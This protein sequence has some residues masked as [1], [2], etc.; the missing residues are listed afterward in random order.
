MRIDELNLIR[1]GRFKDRTL[2]FPAPGASGAPDLHLVIGDNEAGKSTLRK[3]IPEWIWG[4]HPQS[5]MWIGFQQSE[6]RIGGQISAHGQS[7]PFIRKKGRTSTLLDP[8][9]A[10]LPESALS[11]YLAGISDRAY[12]E[13]MFCLD[14]EAMRAGGQALLSGDSKDRFA[15]LLFESAAGIATLKPL[16]EQLEAEADELF[17]ARAKASRRY[18]IALQQMNDA[19]SAFRECEIRVRTYVQRKDAVTD[20]QGTLDSLKR[21]R[22]DLRRQKA[23]LTRVKLLS[24]RFDQLFAHQQQRDALGPLPALP[25]DAQA[26]VQKTLANLARHRAELQRLVNE[27][28]EADRQIAEMT[29]DGRLEAAGPEIS[30]LSEQ[31]AQVRAARADLPQVSRDL[32]TNTERVFVDA[33]H[34]GWTDLSSIEDIRLRLPDRPALATAVNV[35]EERR[36]FDAAVETHRTQAATLKARRAAASEALASL[37]A[38]VD[39]VPLKAAATALREA[40]SQRL[41]PQA[42][43]AAQDRLARALEGLGSF[44]GDT[45]ALRRQELPP[46]DVRRAFDTR[47]T[48]LRAEL[49]QI[50]S[51]IQATTKARVE[52]DQR[53]RRALGAP[54]AVSRETLNAARDARNLAWSEIRDR[55]VEL[56]KAAE[57]FEAAIGT[58]DDLADQRYEHADRAH[59]ADEAQ[60]QI[61]EASERLAAL[62]LQKTKVRES[63]DAHVT[64]WSGLLTFAGLV[65]AGLLFSGADLDRWCVV[66]ARVLELDDALVEL[67]TQIDESNT[68]LLNAWERVIDL[69]PRE[70][71]VVSEEESLERA[72]EAIA[73]ADKIERDRVRLTEA[74]R[75]FDEDAK[76]FVA[77]VDQR[78]LKADD[79][80]RRW[81]AAAV[82]ISVQPDL[83]PAAAGEVLEILKR[84]EP[85]TATCVALAVRVDQMRSTL[86][87]FE[88]RVRALEQQ[89]GG[90]EV[91]PEGTVR[92]LLAALEAHNTRRTHAQALKARAAQLREAAAAMEQTI[93]SEDQGLEDLR[94]IAGVTDP[95]ALLTVETQTDEA[96]TLDAQMNLLLEA[97]LRDGDGLPFDVLATEVAS[98][99]RVTLNAQLDSLAEQELAQDAALTLAAG[100]LAKAVEALEAVGDGDGAARADS[101]RA[102]ALTAMQEAIERFVQVKASA[103]VLRWAIAQYRQRTQGP[104]L[105][106]ASRVFNTL[107]L[108]RYAGLSVEEDSRG[109]PEL[110]AILRDDPGYSGTQRSRLALSEGTLD[111]RYLSLRMAAIEL[112]LQDHPG[113]PVICD[114]LFVNLDDG[115][116]G[117]SMKVLA[118]LAK[119]TQVIYLSH[120]R[121]LE[122]VAVSALGS[123]N[124]VELGRR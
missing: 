91:T 16:L 108:D 78:K 70:L 84:L 7:L 123:L 109:D 8:A 64:A 37:P 101:D 117:A 20:A 82:R 88:E 105:S 89:L 41:N 68:R 66:R 86:T 120:H 61:D 83:D 47:L 15:R 43:K 31:L 52:A 36:T 121:H 122:S 48:E 44:D 5:T 73:A 62:E 90:A 85:A 93:T 33:A 60:R 71:P 67:R 54:G 28:A 77:N 94:L 24:G 97:I 19:K 116:A 80:D 10:P 9:N 42:A 11:P 75:L 87:V 59:A 112:H 106:V 104:M 96:R 12:F 4:I 45:S 107:T 17:G 2:H 98:A 110:V 124:L 63:L 99:D 35:L 57:S 6:M 74:K 111:A 23:M 58:A 79:L 69:L 14:H 114:D 38:A 22:A 27:A 26:R 32:Q 76:V 39:L 102:L 29:L 1:F 119:K 81:R 40:I 51:T 18:D 55:E 100:E 46:A 50:E 21:E 56:D 25:A 113:A 118:D 3:A 13:S 30:E 34:I 92:K 103:T 72:N 53:R 115:R 95:A 49:T 65:G